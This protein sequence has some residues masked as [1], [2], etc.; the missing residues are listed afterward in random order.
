MKVR[1]I[2]FS[3]AMVRA[4]LAGRKTQTRR[5]AERNTKHYEG[6]S[7]WQDAAPGDLLY[8]REN[9]AYVGGGDPGIL[10]YGATWEQDAIA[11]GCDRWPD[12]KCPKL[13][14]CIH[15]PRKISRLTLEVTAMRIE[16]L[17]SISN[18][19]ARCEGVD[20]WPD[21][22]IERHDPF[23]AERFRDLW[24]SLHGAESWDENPD[25]VVLNFHVHRRNV[26]TFPQAMAA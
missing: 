2:I 18:E 1:P 7:P 23:P 4:L 3:A 12:W 15:M 11:A 20:C 6:A 13:T 25:L 24:T 26:D 16:R 8:V 21:M 9:F 17:Q 19:D 10:L 22:L 14:P 5:L